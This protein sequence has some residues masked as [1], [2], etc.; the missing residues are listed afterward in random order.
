MWDACVWCGKIHV[1]MW[2]FSLWQSLCRWLHWFANWHIQEDVPNVDMALTMHVVEW[3]P[4]YPQMLTKPKDYHKLIVCSIPI[5][6][7]FDSWFVTLQESPA[8]VT[9]FFLSLRDRFQVVKMGIIIYLDMWYLPRSDKEP[10]AMTH[11][12]SVV[13]RDRDKNKKDY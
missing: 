8:V 11:D 6:I 9:G 13:S 4:T 5:L 12:L 7:V 3:P 10:M 1:S 2:V